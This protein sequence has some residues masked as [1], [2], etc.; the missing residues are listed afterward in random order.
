MCCRGTACHAP[1][2]NYIA[3][4]PI[5]NDFW[6]IDRLNV[7]IV[8]VPI[9]SEPSLQYRLSA[10]IFLRCLGAIYL[11]AFVS[12]GF[13][14][15]G[16]IGSHGLL[17]VSDFLNEA[18]LQLGLFERFWRA[19]TLFWIRNDNSALIIGVGIGMMVSLSLILDIAPRL[20]CFLLWMF[21]LSFV[22][23]GQDFFHFQWDSLLLE[24]GFLAIFLAP[25]HLWRG[26]LGE[27]EPPQLVRWLFVW[28]LF[29][30]S[31]ESGLSKWLSGDE[32]WRWLTAMDYYY[33]T[34]PI[35]TWLGW[36]A[37]QLPHGFQA[38]SVVVTL[39]IE[40][41]VPFLLFATRQWRIFA[42]IMM[43][44]FQVVIEATANY[45]FFNLLSIALCVLVIDDKIWSRGG[46]VFHNLRERLTRS[47]RPSLFRVPKVLQYSG[48]GLVVLFSILMYGGFYRVFPFGT[49]LVSLVAPLESINSY[50]LFAVMTRERWEIEIQGSRDGVLWK[51]YPFRYKAGD[52]HR[53]PPFVAPHQPRLDFQCWFLTFD[54]RGDFRQHAYLVSLLKGI[55]T[56]NPTILDLLEGNSFSQKGPTYL[57]LKVHRYKMTT[58]A[59]KQMTG[60]YWKMVESRYWSPVLSCPR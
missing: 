10:W 46:K 11:I 32:T 14:V 26:C 33:E 34:A 23:V 56:N 54:G 2:N 4:S 48:F 49:K 39:V 45:G 60:C 51:T 47:C 24:T 25:S 28:L 1:T 52:L 17:P 38:A 5:L 21:Y 6:Q 58:L 57:Q 59:E 31:L 43:V 50:G 42:V 37:H 22:S 20:C 29:R 36:W 40:G 18:K 27:R 9:S 35:P 55:C 41:V 8:S 13:Q 44:A 3:L 53:A 7:G 15:L 30:L 19:P 16:L 12:L